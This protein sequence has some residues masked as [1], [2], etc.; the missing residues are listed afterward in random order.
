VLVAATTISIAN[1]SKG[2][3]RHAVALL[4]S[5]LLHLHKIEANSPEAK[6]PANLH[7]SDPGPDGERCETS[8]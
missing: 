7:S 6:Q 4:K 8:T 2:N 5:G 1:E 3:A